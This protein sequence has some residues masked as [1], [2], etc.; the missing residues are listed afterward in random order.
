[1]ISLAEALKEAE[2]KLKA[3]EKKESKLTGSL[4]PMFLLDEVINERVLATW[5]VGYWQ[6]VRATLKTMIESK[7]KKKKVSP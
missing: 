7:P 5:D 1:M 2:R 6:G 4:S 3:A